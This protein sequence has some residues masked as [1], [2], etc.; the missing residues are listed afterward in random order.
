MIAAVP[1][2]DPT[3]IDLPFSSAEELAAGATINSWIGRS[4]VTEMILTGTPRKAAEKPLPAWQ[5][6]SISPDIKLL[7]PTMPRTT[8]HLKIEPLLSEKSFFLPVIERHVTQRRS[9]DADEKSIRG[10]ARLAS[11]SS[12]DQYGSAHSR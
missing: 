5:V 1:S 10:V 11:I 8:R 9:G 6:T 2:S 3:A 4:R 12:A 7:T